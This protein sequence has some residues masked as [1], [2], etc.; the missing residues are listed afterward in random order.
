MGADQTF[1]IRSAEG[2]HPEQSE[3]SVDSA[4]VPHTLTGVLSFRAKGEKSFLVVAEMKDLAVALEKTNMSFA[5]C[6]NKRNRF[7]VA[8][9]LRMTLKRKPKSDIQPR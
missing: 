9:L 5:H 4:T 1:L 6:G 7:F 8:A 2:C 3:G